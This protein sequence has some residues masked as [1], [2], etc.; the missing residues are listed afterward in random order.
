MEEDIEGAIERLSKTQYDIWYATLYSQEEQDED[1]KLLLEQYK[2][3]KRAN[4]DLQGEQEQLYDKIDK[5]E[6]ENKKYKKLANKNLENEIILREKNAPED[7][8]LLQNRI[9]ELEKVNSSIKYLNEGLRLDKN[10]LT[11]MVN[12]LQEQRRN[13]IPISVIQNKIDELKHRESKNGFEFACKL[14][15]ILYLQELLEERE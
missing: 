5:L 6:E 15:G 3:L 10:I 4:S 7:I 2:D 9:E 11:D 1:I 8:Y 13:S 14:K 12:D